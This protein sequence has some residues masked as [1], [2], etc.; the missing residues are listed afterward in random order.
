MKMKST[1]ISATCLRKVIERI[2]TIGV[3]GYKHIEE[4]TVMKR[5]KVVIDYS[6]PNIAK[7]FHAGHLRST[8]IGN[9]IAN[10]NTTC[11]HNVVR[12]NYLGD[13]GLQFGLLGVGFHRYGSESQLLSNPIQHLYEIYVK[14]NQLAEEDN[15]VI[16]QA[17]EFSHRM[18]QGDI[19]SLRLWKR[20]RQLSI[21]DYT[22]TYQRL[23]IKFDQFSGESEYWDKTPQLLKDLQQRGL[24]QTSD[25]GTQIVDLSDLNPSSDSSYATLARSDGT[26]LY[27]TRDIAAAIDR[28]D[29]HKFDR[30][31][32]VVDKSQSNHFKQLIGV[33]KM[34]KYSWADRIHHISF[35]RVKGMSTRRGEVVFLKDILDEAR[36]RM[37]CNM[38]NTQTTKHLDN[39]DS[40][41]EK[42]GISAIIMR[43]FSGK[44]KK[45]YQFDWDR[46]LQSL[47]NTGVFLQYTHARLY[48][49]ED[50]A[51]VPIPPASAIDPT[52]LQD[53]EAIELLEHL[54]IFDSILLGAQEELQPSV[55]ASYLFKLGHLISVG[56]KVLRVKDEDVPVAQARLALFNSARLT[57]GHG[58]RILGVE[59]VNQM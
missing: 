53:S 37:L 5:E 18:E 34:M 33:L 45:D 11:G 10:I 49:I 9:F 40:V 1:V 12:I 50:Q 15:D 23:G 29:H 41:A 51:S 46:V 30:M 14:T 13:W 43:D 4:T 6:S 44:L 26:S 52:H 32:Y 17:R 42:L 54:A 47:G 7:P 8:I 27:L 55:I 21:E 24:L 31:Y 58:M 2:Q 36:H 3:S 59:P 22:Q 38:Q 19:S 28:Y 20:F 25:K 16:K 57:L 39:Q 35:G 56:Y 48:S